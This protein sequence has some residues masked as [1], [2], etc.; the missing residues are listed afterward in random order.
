MSRKN[1]IF[2]VIFIIATILTI[3]AIESFNEQFSWSVLLNEIQ[4]ADH[5]WLMGGFLCAAGF[6]IFEGMAL[7][8]IARGLRMDTDYRSG[9]CYGAAD[10]FFSA[11]TPSSTGGQPASAFFMIW[12]GMHAAG[13]TIIL[14]IN[15]I[16][17]NLSFFLFGI[18]A[19][20]IGWNEIMAMSTAAKVIIFIGCILILGLSILLMI[21][22]IRNK[23]IRRLGAWLIHLL[24]KMK[25]LRNGFKWQKKLVKTANQFQE[26]AVILRK[27]KPVLTKA[28]VFNILQRLA[29]SLVCVFC[30][31]GIGGAP[32]STADVWAVQMISTIGANG[33]PM[34]GGVGII[35]YLLINGFQAMGGI[36]HP[37]SLELLTRGMSFY[38][39]LLI[40]VTILAAG[41]IRRNRRDQRNARNI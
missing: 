29:N 1:R 13:T 23:Q 10:V 20:V 39:C 7:T 26:C 18:I 12:D 8:V 37:A 6:I 27:N 17:Y 2:L 22:L 4:T 40:S 32:A 28:L 24:V 31:I 15:L 9:I 3:K 25:V 35:D 33:I 30:F 14:I 41:W 5:L 16:M 11:I 36:T 34:P 38:V 21:L 19:L